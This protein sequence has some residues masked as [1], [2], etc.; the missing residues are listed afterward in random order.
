LREEGNGFF[1]AGDLQ[2]AKSKYTRVFAYTKSLTG[3]GNEGADAM[4][5]MALKVS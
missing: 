2:K 3:S 4:V 1:K 5:D